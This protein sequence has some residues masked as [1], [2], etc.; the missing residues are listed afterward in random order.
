MAYRKITV[1]IV[2]NED[3][4]EAILQAVNDAMD[5]IEERNTVYSTDIWDSATREPENAA[6]IAAPAK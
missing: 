4:A 5:R 2:V 3:D 6:E 1:E